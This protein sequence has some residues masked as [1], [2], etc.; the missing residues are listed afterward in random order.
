MRLAELGEFGFIERIRQAVAEAPGVRVGIGDDCAVL[1]LPPGERLLT[2]TDLLIEDIHFRRSWSD[3]VRLGRKSVSVNVSDIAAA[4]GG[5][6][7]ICISVSPFPP[8]CRSKS[9]MPS[10][11]VFSLPAAIT[12]RPWSAATP[13]ARR[14][15]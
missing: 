4:M 2:S 14:A 8:I 7:A 9:W 13:A 3:M 10:S 11:A 5:T 6:P 1:E 15:P 12:A